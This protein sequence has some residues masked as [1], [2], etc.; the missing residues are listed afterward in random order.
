MV[1]NMTRTP[2]AG[3]PLDKDN[4]AEGS[5]VWLRFRGQVPAKSMSQG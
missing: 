5:L 2:R 1:F 4:H 3:F